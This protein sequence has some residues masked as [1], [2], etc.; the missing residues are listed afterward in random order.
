MSTTRVFAR[1]ALAAILLWLLLLQPNA[2][3]PLDVAALLRIPVELPIL[4]LLMMLLPTGTL[5]RAVRAAVVVAMTLA[6]VL[7]VADLAMFAALGR[8]FNPVGDLF[9]VGAGLNL[10]S[11]SIGMAGTSAVV[12]AA[13]IIV[14]IALLAAWWATGVWSAMAA[15]PPRVTALAGVGTAV[16]LLAGAVPQATVLASQQ[17]AG[18][19]GTAVR[20]LAELRAFEA[21]AAVD[22]YAAADGLLDAIDRDVLVVFVES[23][24]RASLDVPL[25]ADLHRRTLAAAEA[26][27]ASLGLA[28][29]SGIVSAPT[30]GGQSWLSHATLANGLRVTDQNQYA[31]VLASGRRTLFEIAREAGF[32]TAAVMPQITMEWP[33]S[34]TMGFDTILAA[35][36]LGYRGRAFN[37]VTMPDQFTL[38]ALDRM[39]RSGVNDRYLFAQVA[40]ASSHAPWVPV[41]E[42]IDWDAIG[43]GSIFDAMAT[44]GDTPEMVWQDRDRVRA[45]YRLAI[46]Y[47]LRTV[48]EYAA[49]HA[50]DPPLM[51]I[52]GDHQAAGFVALDETA[53]VPVHVVGPRHLV[54]R[55]AG[56]GFSEGLIPSPPAHVDGMERLRQLII[57]SFTGPAP[58]A[59][60]PTQPDDLVYFAEVFS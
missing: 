16:A 38:A 48:F 29:R 30:R 31:A 5:A 35:R 7:K 23:Y 33:E 42:L 8:A 60:L 24:G 41:P 44:A 4:L 52:V 54:D 47:S 27:M 58:G 25:Y 21:Q 15:T 50:D 32:R 56:W 3:D 20:T 2:A 9:L 49:R 57:D 1:P 13:M 34:A 36:D 14:V 40:L 43:D 17:L 11:G 22:P 45:Q 37:W 19:A 46:D 6:V 28:M 59:R 39:L 26:P 55:V 51:I 18:K 12:V 10:L 53:D